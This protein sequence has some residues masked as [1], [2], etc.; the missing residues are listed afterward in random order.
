VDVLAEPSVKQYVPSRMNVIVVHLNVV[1]I[2]T[3]VAAVVNV[4]R[5]YDPRRMIIEY[6]PPSVVVH[7]HEY[8]FLPVA[9]KTSIRIITARLDAIAV[10]IPVAVFVAVLIVMFVPTKMATTV[11]VFVLFV[12]VVLVLP[13]SCKSK[14]PRQ[15]QAQ[16]NAYKLAHIPF[17]VMPL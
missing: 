7:R 3:P 14:C 17:S 1:P 8:E 4:V 5:C 6:H 13:W 12:P 2:P 16:P 15:S 11:M 9:L 10:I